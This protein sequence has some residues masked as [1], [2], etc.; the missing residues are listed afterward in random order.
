MRATAFRDLLL[1]LRLDVFD[2]LARLFNP[3]RHLLVVRG[4]L[5]EVWPQR[6][7]RLQRLR[8]LHRRAQVMSGTAPRQ[9][10]HH[11]RRCTTT[12]VAAPYLLQLGVDSG[13]PTHKLVP[14]RRDSQRA[15]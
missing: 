6:V 11:D 5:R 1:F 15:R 3:H 9:T 7:V 8:R 14:A 4:E 10:L 12:T 2:E 13:L